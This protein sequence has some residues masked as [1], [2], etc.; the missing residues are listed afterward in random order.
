MSTGQGRWQRVRGEVGVIVSGGGVIRVSA[1]CQK[2][3]ERRFQA[4]SD[5]VR[6]VSGRSKLQSDVILPEWDE[7]RGLVISAVDKDSDA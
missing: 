2:T 5:G 3:G 1:E 7:R 6:L 4:V